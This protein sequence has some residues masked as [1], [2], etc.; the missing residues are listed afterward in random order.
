M[1]PATVD[2][3]S[4]TIPSRAPIFACVG[5][6]LTLLFACTIMLNQMATPPVLLLQLGQITGILFNGA[7]TWLSIART[8]AREDRAVAL[9]AQKAGAQ[10][11]ENAGAR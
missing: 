8:H 2:P 4:I 7:A 10:E 5:I 1:T 11:L 6:G 9:K 3:N